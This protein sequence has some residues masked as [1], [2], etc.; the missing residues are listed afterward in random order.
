MS[1]IHFNLVNSANCTGMAPAPRAAGGFGNALLP[2]GMALAG[3]NTATNNRYIGI[4]GNIANRFNTRLATV[5]EMGFA[6]AAMGLIGVTWGVTSHQNT[7]AGAWIVT[8]PAPPAGFVAVID[9]V[10]VNFEHLLIRFCMTQLGAGGTVSN[11]VLAVGAYVNPTPNAVTVRLS[12]GNMGGLF[13]A[14]FHQA[15]W[16]VGA[17]F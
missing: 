7:G 4:S 13:A 10:G 11:N 3:V 15:V 6:P 17:G 9:G 14:G 12:W 5:T 8:N 16:G 1:A 2:P